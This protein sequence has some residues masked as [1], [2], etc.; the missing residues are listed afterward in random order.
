[1]KKLS[2]TLVFTLLSVS[3]IYCQSIFSSARNGIGLREYTTNTRGVG[4][5]GTGLAST[6]SL[7]LSAY[8]VASWRYIND[9]KVYL[10]MRYS[11]VNTEL[12]SQSFS[13]STGKF[14]GVML[15][16][17]IKQHHWLLGLSII[18]YSV[19]NFSYILKHNTSIRT[20]DEN[21]FF[22]GNIAR[23]QLSL[24]W[25]PTTGIG[26]GAG[27]NY[28]FGDVRDRYYLF[29]NDP[30]VSDNYYQVEYQVNGPGA[31]ISFDLS[32]LRPFYVGGFL[33]FKPRINFIT[34]TRNPLTLEQQKNK[35]KGS[36]PVF[37]GLGLGY[38]LDHNWVV[39]ADLVYQDFSEGFVRDEPTNFKVFYQTGIG[40]E[41]SHTTGRSRKLF[42]KFDTRLGF[43]YGNLGYTFNNNSIQQ[44]AIHA[45]LGI[46][47]FQNKARL[48]FGFM[49]GLQGSVEKTLA[50]E[51]FFKGFISISAGELWYQKIR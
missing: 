49:G 7:S 3:F 6:D 19:I 40:I 12:A 27:V 32:L 34:L 33:D 18:P 31:G 5:G 13:S 44:Y 48:D 23:S 46:P 21:V 26:L 43:S 9:T 45:G 29:F 36:F 8:N 15:A 35:S 50:R 39:N 47:F 4:M 14:N 24:T 16:V 22:E 51:K 41:H 17:P 30:A 20:Y 37:A 38:Q 28:F 42:N 10:S 1:M 25:S 2:Y 11:Y